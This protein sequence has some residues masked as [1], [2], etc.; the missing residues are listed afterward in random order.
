MQIVL[1]QD[2]D[3]VGFRGQTVNVSPGYA[4]N[5]LIPKGMALLAT[6]ASLN[7]ATEINRVAERKEASA[8]TEAEGR[9]SKVSGVSL[10]ITANAG[11]EGKLFGSVTAS[12]IVEQLNQAVEGISFDKRD[13]LLRDPIKAVG[14]YN[15]KIR[16]FRDIQPAIEVKVVAQKG[17]TPAST[18]SAAPEATPAES[19]SHAE[20]E[21]K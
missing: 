21:A 5:F 12:D 3:G 20:S 4:R 19:A 13:V 17:E 8:R 6:K 1:I 9:A 7:V 10:T 15:V 16:V 14:K 18:P 11:D 2:V